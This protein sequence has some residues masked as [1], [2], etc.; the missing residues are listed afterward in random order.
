MREKETNGKKRE[1]GEARRQSWLIFMCFFAYTVSYVSR[2]SYNCNIVAIRSA[3]NVGNA[4]AG[5]VGTFYFFAYGAGQVI[6]GLLCK[7]YNKKYCV[8]ASLFISAILNVVAFCS[9]AFGAYKWLWL[10]NGAALSVLWSSLVAVLAE[11]LSKE[12]L[13]R[14]VLIMSM[15]VAA[16]TCI[17]YGAGAAF[18][19]LNVYRYSFLLAAALAAGFPFAW[20]LSYN[21]ITSALYVPRGK[22]TEKCEGENAAKENAAPCESEN[23]GENGKKKRAF[24]AW[25]AFYVLAVPGLLAAIINLIKDGLNTWVPQILK[26]TFGYGN[27]LSVALTLVLPLVG[28]GGSAVALF[29]NKKIK[30]F[31]ALCGV[32]YTF[33]TFCTAGITGV[34]Q[35]G[36][37]GVAAGIFTIA[38]FGAISLFAHAVNNVIT[39]IAPIMLRDKY[40]SG[41]LAGVLNGCA[42]VGSTIS[43]YG[44]GALAD[45][46]GWFGVFILLLCLSAAAALISFA[47]YLMGKRAER[48]R[49]KT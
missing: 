14:G 24:G 29:L 49:S 35:S 7:R 1:D 13:K 27:G 15:S 32:L 30:D 39:S 19:A 33:C 26:S 6:N 5:L 44:L 48:P 18:N 20:V 10:I 23:G 37:A 21:K 16:G 11:H 46:Q 2:Y 12:Y 31:L 41:M 45:K 9:P 36:S 38:L 43:A 34:L 42:Y 3:Y 47:V 40:D 25:G 28:M 22:D 17:T 4:E 8:A